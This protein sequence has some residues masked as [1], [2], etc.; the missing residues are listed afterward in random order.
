MIMMI[1]DKIRGAGLG[2]V[3][4]SLLGAFGYGVARWRCVLLRVASGAGIRRRR[5][6]RLA[7]SVEMVM[8]ES[9]GLE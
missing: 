1:S 8:Y 3:F 2:G 6:L 9:C 7:D 4:S 5:A